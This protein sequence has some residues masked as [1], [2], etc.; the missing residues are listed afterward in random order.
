MINL[1]VKKLFSNNVQKFL[2]SII[3]LFHQFQRIIEERDRSILF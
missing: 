1:Q 3:K 2:F